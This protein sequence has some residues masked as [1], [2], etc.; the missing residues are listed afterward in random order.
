MVQCEKC[1]IL[2]ITETWLQE[3]DPYT[4]A[5]FRSDGFTLLRE[6]RVGQ[7]GGGL[8]VLCR[9]EFNPSRP[10][11][12]KHD[13]FESMVVSISSAPNSI[14]IAVIY[15]PP[16]SSC[17]KFIEEFTCFLENIALGGDSIL[18]TG[19]FNIHMD[20]PNETYAKKLADL[21]DAFGL[22]QHVKFP[23][24]VKGHTVDLV[25]SRECDRIQ[26]DRIKRGDLISDHFSI[27]CHLS[28]RCPKQEKRQITYRNIKSM[29]MDSFREDIKRLPLWDDFTN[30]SLDELTDAYQTQLSGLFNTHAPIITR[31]TSV[32]KRD[33]WVNQD[34]LESKRIMRQYERR[35]RK[36]PNSDNYSDFCKHR[37][38][39]R[40]LLEGK[41]TEYLKTEMNKCEKTVNYCINSSTK[42]CIARKRI[43]FPNINL[44]KD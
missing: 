44:I 6:D 34:T 23:T 22:I 30:M 26:P 39:F 1:D 33:P 29:D 14:R 36:H 5:D 9:S 8:A 38:S 40:S 7:K 15:R 17:A 19:D 41:K 13:S 35:F 42:L 12:Q 21:C 18:I 31:N 4:S 43:R 37:N 32:G 28:I 16:N 24:H 27:F 3:G 2:A 10:S 11:S 25:I 20:T